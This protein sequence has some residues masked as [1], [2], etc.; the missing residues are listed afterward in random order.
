MLNHLLD[1]Q[2]LFVI[3]FSNLV[4]EERHEYRIE[5]DAIIF[6]ATI[7]KILTVALMYSKK[8]TQPQTPN[9]SN[10]KKNTKTV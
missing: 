8:S 10:V 7:S 2:A 6:K 1:H 9:V 4:K 3:A 5:F